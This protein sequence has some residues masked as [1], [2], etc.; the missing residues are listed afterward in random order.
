MNIAD[1]THIPPRP[2]RRLVLVVRADPVIC[3]HSGEARCLAEVALTRGFDDVRIVTWPLDRLE[4]AGLPLKPLDHVMPYSPGITVER[5]EPIGDYRVPDGRYL[6]GLTGRLVELF[7]DGVPTVA[8]SL[9]LSPHAVAVHDAVQVARRIGPARVITVAEAVGSDITNVV[10]ECVETGRFGA[11]AHILSVYLASDHCVAVSDYTKDLIV[12]SAATLDAMHGTSFAQRCRDR[13]AISY[14]AVD[15][16][17]Y[18]S[19]TE[20]DITETLG[21]RGL[22]R[23]GYVLFLSRLASAK[24]VDDLIDAYAG[25]RA[26]RHVRLVVA[27]RG[28]HEL[29]I[30]DRVAAAGLEGRVDVLTDVDDAE[31]PALMAGCAAFVLPTR[32]QPE[33]V[34]TFGIALVEKMLAGGGPVITCA[35]GGVPEAVGDTALLVPQHDPTTL[36]EVLDEVVCDWT[37]E[38]KHGAEQRSRAYALQFD[39]AEVFDRLFSL[40]EPPAI[41]VA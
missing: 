37:P 35:T 39:R 7:S 17:A 22:S 5:P 4:E 11:A 1:H 12:A 27:G 6:A 25:S 34:E 3:G 31:K 26:S 20:R 14:P 15:A 24:G 18:L 13:I 16:S 2:T 38:R 9:Y 30:R 21:R 33:F 40:A 10:R 36:R 19:I 23:D 28:P 8:M 41:H 29:A 32:S